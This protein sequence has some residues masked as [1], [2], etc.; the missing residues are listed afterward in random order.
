MA[1]QVFPTL[2]ILA[3][4]ELESDTARARETIKSS[5]E[6]AL[7][8]ANNPTGASWRIKQVVHDVVRY[9][10]K[11]FYGYHKEKD[12]FLR[13]SL[14][15]PQMVRRVADLLRTGA[16]LGTKFQVF[17]SH[18]GYDLQFSVEYNI[19]G[20]SFAYFSRVS[21]RSLPRQ[22]NPFFINA[23]NWKH[24]V[25]EGDLNNRVWLSDAENKVSISSIKKQSNC[26]LEMDAHCTSIL[27]RERVLPEMG[28]QS[29]DFRD[30]EKQLIHSLA[31]I[32]SDER[33]RWPPEVFAKLAAK[34]ETFTRSVSR[35][36]IY[37][38]SKR[39]RDAI[40]KY[41]EQHQ[42]STEDD[43]ESVTGN[44]GRLSR[45]ERDLEWLQNLVIQDKGESDH[46]DDEEDDDLL[47][48]DKQFQDKGKNDHEYEEDDL[49]DE[50]KQFEEEDEGKYQESPDE[51]K[52]DLK[53]IE[54]LSQLPLL[55]QP[56][57]ELESD[58]LIAIEEP[59]R[60]TP[61]I[62]KDDDGKEWILI[63]SND[64]PKTQKEHP[65]ECIDDKTESPQTII[66]QDDEEVV[67]LPFPLPGKNKDGKHLLVYSEPF[68]F[69]DQ[70]TNKRM[71]QRNEA[72]Q[73]SQVSWSTATVK[74]KQ[75]ELTTR[76]KATFERLHSTTSANNQHLTIACTEVH[77]KTR[78]GFVPD[79]Q[80]DP[81]KGVCLCIRDDDS[82]VSKKQDYKETFY[83]FAIPHMT[84][85]GTLETT[86]PGWR[87]I[88]SFSVVLHFETEL[89]LIKSYVAHVKLLDPD[90]MCAFNTKNG[91]YNYICKRAE[92]LGFDA[93][94]ELSRATTEK[95]EW[96]K[97]TSRDRK[98]GPRSI[99]WI[100]YK[101]SERIPGRITFSVWDVLR[102][103]IDASY[104]S[105][106]NLTYE[107]L[108]WRIP[109]FSWGKRNKLWE[110]GDECIVAN[111]LMQRCQ[112]TLLLLDATNFIPQ[113]SECARTFGIDFQSCFDRGSQLRVESVMMR[114]TRSL[115]YVLLS[116][117]RSDV[118]SQRPLECTPLTL[119]P[120]SSL[121]RDPV[122]VLDFQSLYPS[123]IVAYNICF[124]TCLGRVPLEALG[125]DSLPTEYQFGC[126][127]YHLT[128]DI[129]R[130]VKNHV[131]VARNKV[132]F[133]QKEVRKGLLPRMVEDLL[134]T[135]ILVKKAMKQEKAA[136]KPDV[137]RIQLEDARQFSL[138]MVCNFLYGYTS[139]S[140]TGRMPCVDIGDS[141]VDCG[142][143][144]V[145]RAMRLIEAE[146]WDS[147]TE[148]PRVIY[149]NTDSLF[150]TLPGRT[151]EEA[152]VLGQ[153]MA[154]RVTQSN[155][156][157]VTLQFEKVYM[158]CILLAKSK[159]VG[160]KYD[161]PDS[162]PH[163]VQGTWGEVDQE[164]EL[165]AKG[166]ELIRRDSCTLVRKIMDRTLRMIFDSSLQW[167]LS[168]S[169]PDYEQLRKTLG[170]YFVA[171][172]CK[173]ETG[174]PNIGDYVFA[175]EVRLGTYSNPSCLPPAALIA[176]K[177][178]ERDKNAEPLYAER[179]QYVV[180][181]GSSSLRGGTF[182]KTMTLTTTEAGQ[183]GGVGS[184]ERLKDLIVAPQRV[185][186]DQ[187]LKI[188]TEYYITKHVIPMLQRFLTSTINFDMAAWYRTYCLH[189]GKMLPP[190]VFTSW[191]PSHQ[192]TAGI[193]LQFGVKQHHKQRR[194]IDTFF[195]S[196]NCIN[197]GDAI[198]PPPK[199]NYQGIILCIHCR[200]TKAAAKARL[201]FHLNKMEIKLANIEQEC[202]ACCTPFA[203][204]KTTQE[205]CNLEDLCSST[206]C[207]TWYKRNKVYRE[208][209]AL[210]ALLQR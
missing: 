18:V 124:S 53:A 177:R 147:H 184:N 56:Q 65:C 193:T 57:R 134:S 78:K 40:T 87:E 25:L 165:E 34:H 86:G 145:E 82:L 169:E 72:T 175:K 113:T 30:H 183:G 152:F 189:Y 157:P 105:L 28:T 38:H 103:Q 179:V 178:M 73:F 131:F 104:Y 16:V 176:T 139:A 75:E 195:Q 9:R 163:L 58:E 204:H 17:E 11:Q 149:G 198:E 203:T 70:T 81:I 209:M 51:T 181:T 155:P 26:E 115:H 197:C 167:S 77:V 22:R 118:F 71:P 35:S 202:R 69:L 29:T 130:E 80:K 21:F 206:E 194:T 205:I 162:I 129:L 64:E 98:D 126:T 190:F 61:R 14:Y 102:R 12:T 97:D 47:D 148:Q 67:S 7:A 199:A 106:E 88:E 108:G 173:M 156:E 24:S 1:Q 137:G 2:S 36:E 208:K 93:A 122:V 54:V 168:Q 41:L 123:M 32:V 3:P 135:R 132:A 111:Y 196:C 83:I 138:K 13:I 43:C 31:E 143:A 200:R 107:I 63:S 116:C 84:D 46:E 6:R 89:D 19:M 171:Q 95:P 186:H 39:L 59:K 100:L 74:K 85:Q 110:G 174:Q 10:G 33:D 49:L 37:E 109:H 120:P 127:R 119:E 48:E 125:S 90:I 172:I 210:T 91:S 188:N 166:I 192:H 146:R 94:A 160:Y 27:N 151:L 92:V 159:Y 112:A 161:S 142:R 76:V 191:T 4:K 68:P 60:K 158:P 50:D 144:T 44:T 153:R 8:G 133:V 154:E 96:K 5:I 150:V 55:K 114:L 42:T 52:E 79:A 164:P 140:Y 66:I 101:L 128:K 15:D 187:S 45:A 207:P 141:I 201:L 180:V 20:M 117:S 121:N 185:V 62:E 182:A 170:D 136:A 99:Q 23:A